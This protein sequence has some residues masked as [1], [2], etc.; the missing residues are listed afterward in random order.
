MTDQPDP[1]IPGLRGALLQVA[2]LSQNSE[3]DFQLEPDQTARE[4]VARELDAR[5]LRKLR[6]DGVIKPLGRDGFR[7]SARLGATAVQD[8][9]VTLDPVTT[10]VDVD[11]T[12]HF[13]PVHRME[14]PESGSELEMPEDDSIEPLGT[15]I[16]LGAVL[17]EALSL[18][19][20]AYPRKEGADLEQAQFAEEGVTPLSDSDL[21]PFA[22]LAALRDSLQGPTE[23][24]DEE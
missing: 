23:D 1:A 22:S 20:P 19:L 3:T 18:A 10:R 16:D 11:V 14:Q 24:K 17:I 8:C 21:K 2:K 9:V 13:R 6:F 12:R 15:E 5:S 4:A 7:L